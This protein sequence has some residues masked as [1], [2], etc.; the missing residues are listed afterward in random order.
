M[1]KKYLNLLDDGTSD[2]LG[3][4]P[5]LMALLIVAHLVFL[6]LL[7]TFVPF[8]VWAFALGFATC[9]FLTHFNVSVKVSPNSGVR[10]PIQTK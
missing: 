10:D 7:A 6:I 9:K 8:W 2:S 4:D 1:L 5:F 3:R